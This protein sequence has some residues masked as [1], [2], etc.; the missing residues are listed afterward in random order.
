[1]LNKIINKIISDFASGKNIIE[2]SEYR[3]IPSEIFNII[4]ENF[5]LTE[6]YLSLIDCSCGKQC[7]VNKLDENLFISCSCGNYKLLKNNETLAYSI[8]LDKIGDFLIKILDIKKDNGIIKCSQIMHL[9]TKEILNLEFEIYLVR[10]VS[11][12]QDIVSIECKP[13]SK[14][15]PSII[16]DL[17][18]STGINTL[19]NNLRVC[20]FTELVLFNDDLKEFIIKENYLLDNIKGVFSGL[21]RNKIQENLNKKF[22]EHFK[23]L[24]SLNKVESNR[25]TY[26]MS[27]AKDLYNVSQRKFE[28]I[29]K[30]LASKKLRQ[31]GRPKKTKQ[32]IK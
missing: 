27:L 13:K 11:K 24:K 16:I 17:N 26:Y 15:K 18:K 4:K 30:K 23:K 1:M 10:N 6:I 7:K 22:I 9:G 3:W 21:E 8:C 29:W 2:Y 28:E 14:S 5:Q 31:K 20:D 32:M 12:L 25:K 19:E